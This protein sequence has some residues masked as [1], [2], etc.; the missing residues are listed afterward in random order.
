MKSLKPIL[1]VTGIGV[2][3][4]AI[5]NY[6][7]KQLDI[8][9]NYDY[10]VTGLKIVSLQKNLISL[11]ITTRITNY[12]N[13]EA[14]VKQLFLDVYINGVKVGNVDE[15][16]DVFVR[17]N[18]SSDFSFRFSFDPQVVLGN[19]VNIVTLSV[20]IKDVMIELDG[21]VK[22]ESGVLKATVPFNYKNNLKSLIGK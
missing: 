12:S 19:I 1:I 6:Y 18:G 21:Y 10:K 8:I 7:K 3:A 16:K 15:N 14:V 5:Y 4:Y 13:V 11:D 9:K 22:V 17:G 2:I 20:G